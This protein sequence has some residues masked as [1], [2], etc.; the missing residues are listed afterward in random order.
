MWRLDSSAPFDGHA[1]VVELIFEQAG[2]RRVGARVRTQLDHLEVHI[3]GVTVGPC[4]CLRV[5]HDPCGRGRRSLL[6]LRRGECLLERRTEVEV[7]R[8]VA[9][10]LDIGQVGG[11]HLVLALAQR[12][13]SGE[14]LDR[15]VEEV[16]RHGRHS[17]K[18]GLCR[19]WAPSPLSAQESRGQPHVS[20]GQSRDIPTGDMRLRRAPLVALA[21]ALL[22]GCTAPPRPSVTTS[23]RAVGSRT[24]GQK[25]PASPRVSEADEVIPHASGLY[26]RASEFHEDVLAG[27][28]EHALVQ[29]VDIPLFVIRD[30]DVFRTTADRATAIARVLQEALHAGD[31]FFVIGN[32]GELP[33]IQSVSHHGGYPTLVIRVTSGDAAAYARRSGRDVDQ[34]LLAEWWLAVLK[35]VFGVV[36]FNEAPE[37]TVSAD[38]AESLSVLREKLWGAGQTEPV[39]P[40]R[41]VAGEALL[42]A[43]TQRELR[44]LG[45]RV[46]PEFTGLPRRGP[47]TREQP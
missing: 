35:D 43:N 22:T 18:Q 38:A 45:F 3:D 37:F 11:K 34:R 46:P 42:S 24:E 30:E 4:R 9:G 28:H 17:A 10:G 41:L 26:F 5:L 15:L 16:D 2:Q 40:E 20:P 29:L 27:H 6:V 1:Q 13:R 21:L 12:E 44:I 36:F 47:S 25:T 14:A 19:E 8:T 31:R 32:D 7:A 23:K 33:A 39:S